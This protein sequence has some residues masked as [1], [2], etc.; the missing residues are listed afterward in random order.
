MGESIAPLNYHGLDGRLAAD[1][2]ELDRHRKLLGKVQSAG[3]PAFVLP[4]ST[5]DAASVNPTDYL[6]GICPI[7]V[8]DT[9]VAL[10][11]SF[12]EQDAQ[13][14]DRDE[15]LRQLRRIAAIAARFH[16]NS[17][18]R[19]LR[20]G[21]EWWKQFETFTRAAH[22]SLHPTRTA[23][24]IAN[25]GQI[26]IGCDRFTVALRRGRKCRLL[27]ISGQ[28]SINRRANTNVLLGELV[29]RV[30]AA[31]E[32][33]HYPA[34]DDLVPPQLEDAADCY[35]D[36][37]Q[38]RY[39][40]V[41]PLMEPTTGKDEADDRPTKAEVIGALVAEQFSGAPISQPLLE[42]V[43]R[44]SESAL[45]NALEH[46]RV[47]LLPLW[48]AMGRL[49]WL[50]QA[51]TLPK[52][53]LAAVL[54]T[55]IVLALIFVPG[56][57]VL[58]ADGTLQPEVRRY[59]FAQADGVVDTLLVRHGSEV[60]EHQELAKLRSSD[61]DLRLVEIQGELETTSKKLTATKAARVASSGGP[62]GPRADRAHTNQLAAEE[63]ELRRWLSSLQHQQKLLIERQEQLVVRSPI[64]GEV[65]TWDVEN[66]LTARPVTKG[67]TLLIVAQTDGPW[68]LE[69]LLA[70]QRVG[71][72]RAAQQHMDEQLR[73]TFILATNPGEQLEGRIKRS[74]RATM[75]DDEVGLALPITVEIDEE[76]IPHLRPGA[77]VTAK[78]HCGRR[79]IGYVWLHEL[80][81]FVQSRILF[82]FS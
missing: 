12:H 48:A 32:A 53:L 21:Q 75:L 60:T 34:K 23:Y 65:I 77:K 13:P 10:L 17:E 71:H 3:Q 81:E 7:K 38:V 44:Q 59:V 33:F 70:D 18:L 19:E 40:T 67:E 78:I 68:V 47:F 73:V 6:L 76:E 15:A 51:R 29:A 62:G 24:A 69:L 54:V 16:H 79:P 46:H 28:D 25:E 58:T 22:D 82:R 39:L 57:F 4:Q 64:C 74:A 66:L 30:M 5:D 26:V 50:V 52:T 27:A 14:A 42:A 36:S 11:E 72:L 55:A 80:F 8:D 35:V 37:S 20:R 41:F 1:E 63:E 9:V 43:G 45:G 49:G 2:D 61:I 31:G 56:N